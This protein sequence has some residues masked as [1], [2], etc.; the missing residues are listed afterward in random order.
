M[1]RSIKLL[2]IIAVASL[3]CACAGVGSTG[4]Q[5]VDEEFSAL[6]STVVKEVSDPQRQVLALAAVDDL[7]GAIRNFSE[8]MN[9][10]SVEIE[11]L[12]RDP[13]TPRSSFETAFRDFNTERNALRRAVVKAHLELLAQVGPA[14]WTKVAEQEQK[15]LVAAA[16]IRV[17]K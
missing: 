16:S 13:D 2:W 7:Q 12:N 4:A 1:K 10:F 9:V 11:R 6:R 5:R 17:K 3:L 14:S 15:A 8:R